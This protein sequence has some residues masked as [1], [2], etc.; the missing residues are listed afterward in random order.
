MKVDQATGLRGGMVVSSGVKS[1]SR[2]R[3]AKLGSRPAARK[4]SSSP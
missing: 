2:A 4:R 1:P 3:L